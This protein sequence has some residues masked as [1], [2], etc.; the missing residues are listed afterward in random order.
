MACWE[1]GR[2]LR[3]TPTAGLPRGGAP[4]CGWDALGD[5]R[6]KVPANASWTVSG[7]R[8]PEAGRPLAAKMGRE[9]RLVVSVSPPAR[10]WKMEEEG[11]EVVRVEVEVTVSTRGDSLVVLLVPG[12]EVSRSNFERSNFLFF[13]SMMCLPSSPH[14]RSS[15]RTWCPALE[16]DTDFPLPGSDSL[17]ILGLGVSQAAVPLAVLYCTVQY[18]SALPHSL[19]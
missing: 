1:A 8:K 2:W 16:P 9:T 14:S 15:P 18:S 17:I 4:F 12:L 6:K 5:A 7:V 19:E 3:S 10:I 11:R 13:G